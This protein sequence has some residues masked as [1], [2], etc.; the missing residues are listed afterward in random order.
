MKW[1]KGDRV[2]LVAMPSDPAPVPVGMKGTVAFDSATIDL[3]DGPWEQVP[4]QWDN[5][6]TLSACIPPDC[7]RTVYTGPDVI[8]V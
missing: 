3:G 7:I 2:Y 8:E 5:G 1:Y 6:S 4:I